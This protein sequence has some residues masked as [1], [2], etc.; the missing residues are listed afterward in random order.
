M[1]RFGKHCHKVLVLSTSLGGMHESIFRYGPF[2]IFQK[3][4]KMFENWPP[5]TC[6]RIVQLHELGWSQFMIGKKLGVPK[7]SVGN[8]IR[9]YKSHDKYDTLPRVGRPPQISPKQIKRIDLSLQEKP[10]LSG[11]ELQRKQKLPVTPRH[12]NRI[13]Q[14]TLGYVS[15]K[16]Q[17]IPKLTVRMKKERL[18]YALKHAN[19]STRKWWSF[20][21]KPMQL[22]RMVGRV[23]KRAGDP[24]PEY[25]YDT[26]YAHQELL[27]LVASAERGKVASDST[28]EEVKQRPDIRST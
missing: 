21:E 9:R 25:Q 1:G 20:D 16:P 12:V 6:A 22:G 23:R 24:T 28:V 26:K 17:P 11:R 10:H 19:T 8:I 7:S 14:K 3:F 15:V 5:T 18:A 13:V 2:S 4:G 27:L